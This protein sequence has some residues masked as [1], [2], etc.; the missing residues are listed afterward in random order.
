MMVELYGQCPKEQDDGRHVN[1]EFHMN[2]PPLSQEY[3]HHNMLL[4]W[5]IEKCSERY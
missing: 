4:I 5:D 1:K 3:I 2:Q